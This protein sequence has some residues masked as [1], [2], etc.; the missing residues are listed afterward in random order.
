MAHLPLGRWCALGVPCAAGSVPRGATACYA[1]RPAHILRRLLRGSAV[2]DA[3]RSSYPRA[4]A[5][6]KGFLWAGSPFC[7]TR[8]CVTLAARRV[9]ARL[10]RRHLAMC[11]IAPHIARASRRAAQQCARGAARGA[12]QDVASFHQPSA[13]AS[14][15]P[16]PSRLFPP[17]P[18][19]RGA[20]IRAAAG[21]SPGAHLDHLGSAAAHSHDSGKAAARARIL[22]PSRQPQ[23]TPPREQAAPRGAPEARRA[24]DAPSGGAGCLALG[25]RVGEGGG[26]ENAARQHVTGSQQARLSENDFFSTSWQDGSVPKFDAPQARRRSLTA[27]C[28]ALRRRRLMTMTCAAAAS[29]DVSARE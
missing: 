29:A 21:R 19:A 14:S 18:A 15:P 16:P 3:P 13:L 12:R 23:P 1:P 24:S 9:R 26:L 2:H 4:A 6:R 5:R 22:L 28:G 17:L 27:I 8:W 11:T 20:L 7:G 10:A 25:A